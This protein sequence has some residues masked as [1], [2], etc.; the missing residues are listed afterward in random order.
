MT[1]RSPTHV[2]DVLPSVASELRTNGHER[3]ASAIEAGLLSVDPAV[4]AYPANAILT[5]EQVASWLQISVRSVERLNLRCI[6]LGTR[7]RRYLAE[8]I[9]AFLRSKIA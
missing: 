9:L 6:F 8:D 3:A 7:T 1:R 5:I 2:G 4:R